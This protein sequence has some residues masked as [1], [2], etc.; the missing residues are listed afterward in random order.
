MPASEYCLSACKRAVARDCSLYQC[1]SNLNGYFNQNFGISSL[2]LK[3]NIERLLHRLEPNYAL[4]VVV[5]S[6]D[7]HRKDKVNDKIIR[8]STLVMLL[9]RLSL[10]LN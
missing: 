8:S 9:V 6:I 4:S 7:E 2:V 10:G 1:V 5:V 3:E